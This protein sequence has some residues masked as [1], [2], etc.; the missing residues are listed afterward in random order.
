MATNP[1]N[2]PLGAGPRFD[3][4]SIELVLNGV[5]FIGCSEFEW[6]QSLKPVEVR[7]FTPQ[8]IGFTRGVYNVSGRVTMY[9]SEFDFLALTISALGLGFMEA[10][11]LGTVTYQE[12]Q[13]L[14]LPDAKDELFGIRFTEDAHKI[15]AGSGDALAV[16]LPFVALYA[17]VNGLPA[18][19]ALSRIATSAGAAP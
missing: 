9:R 10:M 19:G 2:Y 8:A 16:D 1:I 3:A 15:S 5:R 4:S 18:F 17:L 11:I 6:N 14:L 12:H 7:G 13:P